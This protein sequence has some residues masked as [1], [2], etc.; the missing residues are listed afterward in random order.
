MNRPC[1]GWSLHSR[2][3]EG[4]AQ[5][6]G[7]KGYS[8]LGLPGLPTAKPEE[9]GKPSGRVA[10]RASLQDSDLSCP[11]VFCTP[12]LPQWQPLEVAASQLCSPWGHVADPG[13]QKTEHTANM[14]TNT[15]LSEAQGIAMGD[16]RA[17]ADGDT[18]GFLTPAQGSTSPAPWFIA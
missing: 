14:C 12:S 8:T 5:G 9:T 10:S 16:E 2:A 17:Q 11:L 6:C 13:T 7:H 3:Q 1:H 4:K 18:G 15:Q